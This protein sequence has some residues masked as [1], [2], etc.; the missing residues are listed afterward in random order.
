MGVLV[1]PMLVVGC[2][3]NQSSPASGSHLSAE[4]DSGV[5][6]AI[7]TKE[8]SASVDASAESSIESVLAPA[9]APA[10]AS[11]AG[12]PSACEWVDVGDE[13][14]KSF[15][16]NARRLMD[17]F[18]A[19]EKPNAIACCVL[20]EGDAL[21]RTR[22]HRMNDPRGYRYAVYTR[23]VGVSSRTKEA[24][25][26]APYEVADYKSMKQVNPPW[27]LELSLLIQGPSFTL[28][29][30]SGKCPR[31]CAK[32]PKGCKKWEEQADRACSAIGTYER[33]NGSLIRR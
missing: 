10:A 8:S 26:D 12:A 33:A 9:S 32:A 14:L 1:V 22:S 6:P 20:N 19:G 4:S 7:G 17:E 15:R 21:C 30:A 25:F 23:L 3:A 31:A 24:W 16:A 13:R 28:V 27:D 2:G 29:D 11:D 5:A 18:V